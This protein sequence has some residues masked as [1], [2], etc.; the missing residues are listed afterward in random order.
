[1]AV[2]AYAEFTELTGRSLCPGSLSRAANGGAWVDTNQLQLVCTRDTLG[3][4]PVHAMTVTDGAAIAD[5]VVRG[6]HAL[7]IEPRSVVCLSGLRVANNRFE[8]EYASII[9]DAGMNDLPTVDV[10]D[11]PS[12]VPVASVPASGVPALFAAHMKRKADAPDR[13]DADSAPGARKPRADNPFTQKQHVELVGDLQLGI[14]NFVLGPVLVED[15]REG[16][17][18]NNGARRPSTFVAVDS[19]N[20]R[21][22]YKT[23]G[24]FERLAERLEK[25]DTD[26]FYLGGGRLTQ[27]NPQYQRRGCI[28][29]E[30]VIDVEPGRD[31]NALLMVRAAGAE[32]FAYMR[33]SAPTPSAQQTAAISVCEA[34]DTAGAAGTR[35]SAVTLVGVVSTIEKR[36]SARGTDFW[37]VELVDRRPGDAAERQLKFTVF[38][39]R[40]LVKGFLVVNRLDEGFDRRRSQQPLVVRLEGLTITG[41]AKYPYEVDRD[42]RMYRVDDFPQDRLDAVHVS[43]LDSL[44]RSTLAALLSGPVNMPVTVL[45]AAAH[46]TE[47][48]QTKSAAGRP[49]A[50]RQVSVIDQSVGADGR[51]PVK[52]IQLFPGNALITAIAANGQPRNAA[53]VTVPDAQREHEIT[54]PSRVVIA[55]LSGIQMVPPREE[56]GHPFLGTRDMLVTIVPHEAG[57]QDAERLRQWYTEKGHMSFAPAATLSHDFASASAAPSAP[58][59]LSSYAASS[60]DGS[61]AVSVPVGCEW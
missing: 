42:A 14:E 36:V 51:H 53:F 34:I 24:S 4:A 28:P 18:G 5:V 9:D 1:M 2:C 6:T 47:E 57:D 19:A 21:V 29:L 48:R 13:T 55:R 12:V 27:V 20:T 7:S 17:I 61:A 44:P 15:L 45:V 11:M 41:G 3:S 25:R 49:Y 39:D 60:N 16:T 56:T 31:D 37:T 33:G 52:A 43:Q 30:I 58:S 35:S 38:D 59:S 22:A 32:W 46:M 23:F 8:A 54:D 26:C 50:M 40:T 10:G